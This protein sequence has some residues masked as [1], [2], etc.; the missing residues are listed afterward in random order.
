MLSM[1]AT[2]LAI[3]IAAAAIAQVT[4]RF[5]DWADGPVKHLMTKE[6]MKQWKSLRSDE[7]RQD[8]ID[9]FWAKRDPTPDTARNEFHEEFDARVKLAD[10]QFSNGRERGAMTDPGKVLILLG[11]PYRV[12]GRTGAPTISSLGPIGRRAPTDAQGRVL[13]P[14]PTREPN[15]LVW[16]YAHDHKPKYIPE[17]DFVLVFL[18]QDNNNFELAHTERTNPD[19]I[20]QQAVVGLIVSPKLTKAPFRADASA[21][22]IHA[23]AFRDLLL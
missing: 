2:I 14:S 18:D 3:L 7:E 20:L 16:T 11:T 15:R 8:F 4:Y 9:L 21:P 17:S 22:R 12:S 13:V 6:E 23:K 19:A 1:R 10:D 5:A